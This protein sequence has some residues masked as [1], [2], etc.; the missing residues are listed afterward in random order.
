MPLT[1]FTLGT[2]IPVSWLMYP[3]IVVFDKKLSGLG[4]VSCRDL[5]L[6]QGEED[7]ICID[8]LPLSPSEEDWE[9][10][11]AIA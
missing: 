5:H 1:V 10:R 4:D 8:E 6:R 11:R 3:S 9:S 7:Q 2:C